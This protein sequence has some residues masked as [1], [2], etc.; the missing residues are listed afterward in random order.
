MLCVKSM[1]VN[2]NYQFETIIPRR[3]NDAEERLSE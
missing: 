2:W 3:E 1:K